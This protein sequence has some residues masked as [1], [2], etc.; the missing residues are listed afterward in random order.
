MC[1]MQYMIDVSAKLLLIYVSA[2]VLRFLIVQFV[3][4]VSHYNLQYRNISHFSLLC[5]SEKNVTLFI[6]VIILP[7]GI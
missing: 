5:V 2:V 3:P 4:S 1:I 7:R 6:V